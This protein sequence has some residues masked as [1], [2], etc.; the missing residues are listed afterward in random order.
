MPDD[1]TD[2]QVHWKKG[3]STV[4]VQL[5]ATGHSLTDDYM[6]FD[7]VSYAKLFTYTHDQHYYDVA[8]ILLH[9]TKIM[10]CLPAH[11]YDL[12]QYGW[13]QEHW[14]IAPSRRNG[15]H[16]GWLALVTCSNI[17]G[18]LELEDFDSGLYQKMISDAQL[19]MTR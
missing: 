13:Q 17:Q 8:M 12:P 7:V 14:S 15:M 16:R 6:A 2:I 1:A 4:G 11:P 9:N 3:V 18:I 10:T 19:Q 5:I